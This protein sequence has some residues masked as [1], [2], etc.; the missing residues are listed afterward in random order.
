M[1]WAT[2]A[3]SSSS[4]AECAVGRRGWGR[5]AA[6]R[7]QMFSHEILK[8]VIS[9]GNSLTRHGLWLC[10]DRLSPGPF[11]VSLSFRLGV[12]VLVQFDHRDGVQVSCWIEKV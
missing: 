11:S 12:A 4:T 6:P 7:V 2:M 1:L 8:T 3:A 5:G 10:D 9:D